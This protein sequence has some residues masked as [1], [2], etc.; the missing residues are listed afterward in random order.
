MRIGFPHL[1]APTKTE[2]DTQPETEPQT[3]PSTPPA[4]PAAPPSPAIPRPDEPTPS[5]CPNV[6]PGTETEPCFAGRKD[7]FTRRNTI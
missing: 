2:P 7:V 1:T 6:K 3:E 4:I 5:Q